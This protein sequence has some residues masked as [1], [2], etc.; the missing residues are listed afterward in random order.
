MRVP[1]QADFLVFGFYFL[2][3][4]EV[5]KNGLREGLKKQSQVEQLIK[6]VW[7]TEQAQK[8]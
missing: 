8:G 4:S 6:K 7:C 2:F 5:K 1:F 3:F